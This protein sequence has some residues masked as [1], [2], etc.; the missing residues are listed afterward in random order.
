MKLKLVEKKDEAKGTKSFYWESEKPV[1]YI[2]G[3][4]YYFTLSTLKYPDPRGATRHFTLSSSPTDGNLIRNTTRIRP[5]SGFKKTL[6]ELEIGT[7]IDGEGPNGTFILDE[8]E[9][10]PHVFLA[11]GIGITPFRSMIKYAADKNLNTQIHLIYSNSIPE[12][13]TFRAE[14]ENL[15]KSWP[16]LKLDMTITKPEESKEQWKGLTGRIDE[17]LI[18]KLVPDL[19][20]NIFWVCGP[21]V[22]VEA[23]EQTLGKLNLSAGKVRSEKF[24][25]Y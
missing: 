14:L 6:D 13:I 12:E 9:P 20:N 24:T 3:Q 15:A 11:G 25:G 18:Q 10:G 16:N 5:E 8:A 22:M 19:G 17:D 7:L 23:M 21:P 1:K 2:A 4:Y